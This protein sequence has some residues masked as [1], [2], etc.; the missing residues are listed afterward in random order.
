M[1]VVLRLTRPRSKVRENRTPT[2]FPANKVQPTVQ[3]ITMA[4]GNQHVATPT[5]GSANQY[6]RLDDFLEKTFF[7]IARLNIDWLTFVWP[8]STVNFVGVFP[9]PFFPSLLKEKRKKLLKCYV[10]LI[11]PNRGRK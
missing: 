3:T 5:V 10:L 9:E 11:F 1:H 4:L 6:Q 7:E 2:L 8:T